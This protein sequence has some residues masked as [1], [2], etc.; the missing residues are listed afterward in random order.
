MLPCQ[1]I[2]KSHHRKRLS[3]TSLL[4]RKKCWTSLK[5]RPS[6]LSPQVTRPPGMLVVK[7]SNS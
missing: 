1:S 4:R 6:N 5:K 7:N 2:R 3:R